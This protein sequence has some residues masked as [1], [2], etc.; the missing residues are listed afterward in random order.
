MREGVPA[1]TKN[2]K[3]YLLARKEISKAA[4]H[5]TRLSRVLRLNLTRL[6]EGSTTLREPR[7]F[8]SQANA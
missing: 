5:K 6:V 8:A 3:I 4:A 7:S 1:L 2:A